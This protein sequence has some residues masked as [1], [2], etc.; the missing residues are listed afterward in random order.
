MM[1]YLKYLLPI[2]LFLPAIA[3][4]QNTAPIPTT[5]SILRPRNARPS[6]FGLSG[7][8]PSTS[9][10]ERTENLNLLA[11]T[12]N[13]GV[14]LDSVYLPPDSIYNLTGETLYQITVKGRGY[15]QV[16]NTTDN[17]A[18]TDS[19]ISITVR[20]LTRQSDSTATYNVW[21][22][23]ANRCVIDGLGFTFNSNVKRGEK[24]EFALTY[25]KPLE[26]KRDTN[27]GSLL[28]MDE[29]HRMAHKG[30]MYFVS[31]DS[32]LGA[33]N[34]SLKLTVVTPAGKRFHV[35]YTV[36]ASAKCYFVIREDVTITSG[37]TV[38]QYNADRDSSG[39]SGAVVQRNSLG[40]VATG[41]KLVPRIV[42]STMRVSALVGSGDEIILNAS[43]KYAFIVHATAA[44]DA[45]M[46]LRYYKED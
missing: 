40:M 23:R 42:N 26:F 44:A 28:V 29:A 46:V 9:T 16:T 19:T 31:A 41:T 18:D 1:K 10:W 8:F 5:F 30:R 35:G 14:G 24:Y 6:D 11:Y 4:T 17:G 15:G 38:T 12:T 3:W 45:T 20:K 27:S 39:A 2:L 33:G 7:M 21:R 25:D 34:D 36:D 43:S 37:D 32:A 22:K 13:R